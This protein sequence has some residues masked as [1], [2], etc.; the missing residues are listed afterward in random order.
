MAAW[1]SPPLTLFSPATPIIPSSLRPAP[2]A[3]QNVSNSQI[4]LALAVEQSGSA[5]AEHPVRQR[6]NV[7]NPLGERRQSA[8]KA[9]RARETN[10]QTGTPTMNEAYK[11]VERSRVESSWVRSQLQISP[12]T[13]QFTY[14]YVFT[15][16]RASHTCT[17]INVCVC[18]CVCT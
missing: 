6:G 12:K 3:S 1:V 2:P 5:A 10:S 17:C 9:L 15:Y 16:T 14:V 18:V 4:A 13:T 7:H 8:V 11:A